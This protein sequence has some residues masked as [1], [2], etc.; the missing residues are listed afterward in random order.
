MKGWISIYRSL[1]EKDLWLKEKF[2]KGQAWID[3]I[4]LANHIKG[5]IWVRGIH[6]PIER[7]QVGW[8]ELSLSTRWKWSR[9][10]TKNFLKF[11]ENEQQI[12]QQR[13]N[14]T[15]IITILNYN[16][17]QKNGIKKEQ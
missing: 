13:N 5:F 11:L 12:V 7:G 15:T 3:L 6:I 2:T 8:S 9:T 14:K 17:Y 4:M 16:K 10:R 1:A